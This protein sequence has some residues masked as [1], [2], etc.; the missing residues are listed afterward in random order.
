[1]NKVFLT[2]DQLAIT[3]AEL[4]EQMGYGKE[5]PD[6]DT[7]Q[8]V[9]RVL[10]EVRA[11][12]QPSFCFFVKYGVLDLE[13]N[14]LTIDDTTLSIGK[15][16]ARQLRGA[17][18]YAFIE[19]LSPTNLAIMSTNALLSLDLWK[20]SPPGQNPAAGKKLAKCIEYCRNRKVSTPPRF[21]FCVWECGPTNSPPYLWCFPPSLD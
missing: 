12:L 3:P 9:E 20:E 19:S 8:E 21:A 11:F 5:V 4:Y 13:Q 17:E 10:Q 15:I 14:T 6:E 1:M 18:A 7:L 2:Y 16:I